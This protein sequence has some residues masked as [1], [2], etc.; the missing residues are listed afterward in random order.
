VNAP[1]D[2]LAGILAEHAT[3]SRKPE[4]RNNADRN[5]GRTRYELRC[6]CGELMPWRDDGTA[7]LAHLAAVIQAEYVAE[8]EAQAWERG[9]YAGR[10]YQKRLYDYAHITSIAPGPPE[11]PRNPYRARAEALCAPYGDEQGSGVLG[12][13]R[14][15]A[16]NS[17]GETGG[18]G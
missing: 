17:E 16:G 14:D 8:R 9:A 13:G 7:H 11:M 5:L 4:P 6:R 3:V 1:E 10:E 2:A 15:A 18:E 12:D